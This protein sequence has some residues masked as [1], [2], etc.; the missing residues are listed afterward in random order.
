MLG[1]EC[2]SLETV[3]ITHSSGSKL[4]NDAPKVDAAVQHK[5]KGWDTSKY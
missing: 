4:I 1:K 3:S 2:Y 5:K